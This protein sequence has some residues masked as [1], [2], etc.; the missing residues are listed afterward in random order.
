MD[1]NVYYDMV[2]MFN[3]IDQ[4]TIC[5]MN[6]LINEWMAEA[7]CQGLVNEDVIKFAVAML[8]EHY[9]DLYEMCQN[10]TIG[11]V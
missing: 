4:L 9:D 10:P 1:V 8:N 7:C 6:V 11:G 3:H 5:P 2:D